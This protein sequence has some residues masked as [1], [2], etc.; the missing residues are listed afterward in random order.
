MNHKEIISQGAAAWS[1]LTDDQKLPYNQK[2]E[3]EKEKYNTLLQNMVSIV[4]C[5]YTLNRCRPIPSHLGGHCVF[6]FID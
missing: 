1:R 5:S 3:A 2:Y 6:I 4:L